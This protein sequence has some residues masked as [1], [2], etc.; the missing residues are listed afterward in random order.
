MEKGVNFTYDSIH[1][2][3]QIKLDKVNNAKLA[4]RVILIL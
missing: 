1:R 3:Y 2:Y 4:K